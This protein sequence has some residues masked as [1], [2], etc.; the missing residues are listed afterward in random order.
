ME[1]HE[2]GGIHGHDRVVPLRQISIYTYF[3]LGLQKHL[4]SIGLTVAL[5]RKC[6]DN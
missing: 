3:K 2:S 5:R 6:V 1:I 4:H